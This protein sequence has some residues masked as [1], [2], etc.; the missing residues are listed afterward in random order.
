M[1][2]NTM[3]SWFTFC[4]NLI[5]YITCQCVIMKCKLCYLQPNLTVNFILWSIDQQITDSLL[6][7][8]E[9]DAGCPLS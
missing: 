9:Q 5:S 6:T 3:T 7:V 2:T 8:R 4:F 1:L